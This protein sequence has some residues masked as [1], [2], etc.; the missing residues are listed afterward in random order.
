MM[1][2]A[3]HAA[4]MREQINAH[5]WENNFKMDLKEI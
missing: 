4:C 3:R 2:Y 5:R 1:Q